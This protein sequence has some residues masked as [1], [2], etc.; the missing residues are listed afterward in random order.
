MRWGQG[1]KSPIG[2]T[3]T[4]DGGPGQ[5]PRHPTELG[6]NRGD[7][8]AGHVEGNSDQG[9]EHQCHKWRGHPPHQAGPEHEDHDGHRTDHDVG[10]PD[11][12]QPAEQVGET[13]P[14]PLTFE[15]P[16]PQEVTEL[17]DGDD[18]GDPGGESGGHRMGHELDQPAQPEQAHHH[19][20]ETS[21]RRGSEQP[22]QPELGGDRDQEDHERSSRARN[23]VHRAAGQGDDDACDDGRVQPV[24]RGCAGRDGEGHRKRECH[25][26]QDQASHGISPE[27][28]SHVAA[29]G[30]RP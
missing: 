30:Y 24:L 21:H 7:R 6:L 14:Y 12:G 5:P 22:D 26:A 15:G 23:C 17:E 9:G 3:L 28:G 1:R 18:N 11:L 19:Q 13:I 10:P 8:V 20:N 25:Q 2:P 27:I 29:L 4:R 16:Q